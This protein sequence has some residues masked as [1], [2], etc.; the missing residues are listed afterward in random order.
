MILLNRFIPSLKSTRVNTNPRDKWANIRI[1]SKL[2]INIF[3]CFNVFIIE[4]SR[5]Y[6]L[7]SHW[8]I[9]IG[10]HHY[11][12]VE[13]EIK[14]KYKSCLGCIDSKYAKYMLGVRNTPRRDGI[15]KTKKQLKKAKQRVKKRIHVC[16]NSLVCETLVM[17][18]NLR[19]DPRIV[20]FHDK[21]PKNVSEY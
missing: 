1:S 13:Y 17:H 4:L 10:R 3:E 20:I 15:N 12:P 9:T 6:G 14:L 18:N 11:I 16:T 7:H 21:I 19:G 2:Y 8:A 5:G